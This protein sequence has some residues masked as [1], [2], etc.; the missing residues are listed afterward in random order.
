MM[1]VEGQPRAREDKILPFEAWGIKLMSM[2]FFVAVDQPV[3]WRG[4]M[5]HSAIQQFMTDVLWGPLDYLL[6]DMP[7]GTGDV[8]LS[9]SQIIPL[10]GAVIVTTPQDV[11]LA[12][13]LKGVSAFQQLRVP[14]LGVVENMSGF[15]C[16]HCGER[17]D[18]FSHGGGKY[19]AENLKVPFLGEIAIDPAIRAGGDDGHPITATGTHSP[20]AKE[21]MRI[22]EQLA[23]RLSVINFERRNEGLIQIR[24]IPISG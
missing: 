23:A 16:S 9:L 21:F 12:D 18:I 11:A 20:Q 2:G 8:Q 14:I 3:V 7:P 6:I 15:V 1:G 4:P 22:A 13:V 5:L 17:T 24:D 10:T 19:A